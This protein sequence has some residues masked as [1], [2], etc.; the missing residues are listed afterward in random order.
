MSASSG[1]VPVREPRKERS[2]PSFEI[3]EMSASV[4]CK[5][6]ASTRFCAIGPATAPMRYRAVSSVMAG[7]PF[8][9]K[10]RST[11]KSSSLSDESIARST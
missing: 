6:E 9:L 3:F 7:T 2:R 5:T 11:A 4:N 1:P 8:C 10:D